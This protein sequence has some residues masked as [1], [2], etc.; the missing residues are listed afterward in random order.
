MG[1]GTAREAVQRPVGEDRARAGCGAARNIRGRE[2]AHL[3][4]R[5]D[6]G[7][8]AGG[9][10]RCVLCVHAYP[11]AFL[12]RGNRPAADLRLVPAAVDVSLGD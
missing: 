2:G 3:E 10:E 1:G 5:L 11:V 7:A 4:G 12:Q 8:A 9:G 6:A